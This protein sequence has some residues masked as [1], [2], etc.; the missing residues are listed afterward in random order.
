M[1]RPFT[2]SISPL[3]SSRSSTLPASV[4]IGT[5]TATVKAT[6]TLWVGSS[7][8]RTTWVLCCRCFNTNTPC[9]RCALSDTVQGLRLCSNVQHGS[10]S[11]FGQSG[12]AA[13]MPVR[14]GLVV[15]ELPA[16]RKAKW[17][18]LRN[19][20]PTPYFPTMLINVHARFHLNYWEEEYHRQVKAHGSWT[21]KWK[22]NG[23][24]FAC[25]LA[26]ST[27]GLDWQHR[28]S[29][30]LLCRQVQDGQVQPSAE[31]L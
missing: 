11:T 18:G 6:E 22:R 23:C 8:M 28:R 16:G 5:T 20:P 21:L 1:A 4:M 7:L 25:L 26:C 27:H 29:R 31:P 3:R 2:T 24:F 19:R 10:N 9:G 15:H 17:A 13:A 12:A 14:L 30:L